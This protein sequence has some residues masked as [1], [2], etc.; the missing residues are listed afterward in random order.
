[1]KANQNVTPIF[2]Q[3]VKGQPLALL[4]AIIASIAIT[5]LTF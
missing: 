1:M 2:S 3:H 5:V 4:L